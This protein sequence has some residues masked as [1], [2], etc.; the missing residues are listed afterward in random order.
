MMLEAGRGL[1]FEGVVAKRADSV[2]EPDTRSRA[3]LKVKDVNEQ[4]FVVGGFTEGE[5]SRKNTFGGLLI[6]YYD[7]NDELKFAS[8]V[9]SGLKDT[10]LDEDRKQLD[11]LRTEESPFV[12]PPSASGTAGEQG[13]RR[14][15]TG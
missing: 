3:W 7:I 15:A 1:G 8:S 13:M 4:E 14:R 9:G 5:G 12:N 6:G 2:Y 10:Q 11:E